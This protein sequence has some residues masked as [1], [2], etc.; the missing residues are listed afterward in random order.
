MSIL[1]KK[2]SGDLVKLM[3]FILVTSL[4]TG[5]LVVLIGNFTFESTRTYKAQ[6]SDATGVVKGDDIRIAGVKVGSVKDVRIV[7]RERAEVTFGVAR[8]SVVTKS[9]TATIRYRN[10]VGQRYIALT[11]GVGDLD[12][13][14][15]DATIPMDRTKPALDLTV[16]FNGFKPLFAALSP[17]DINKLSAEVISV[18]QGEGGTLTSLLQSTASLTNTL[19]DRDKVIGEVIDN[20]NAVLAT[21]AGRDKQLNELITDFQ[22]L[23]SGLVQDRGAILGSLDSV[24]ALADETSSLVIGIRPSL[25]RDVKGLRKVAANLNQGRGE[26]DRALQVLPIKLNKIGRTAIYGSFFNFYLCQFQGNVKVGNALT[27]P[28]KYDTSTFSKDARC[29]LG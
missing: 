20:L 9:S 18:F 3:I 23:M 27:V 2:T 22:R 25:V 6:F 4:A 28:I 12:R 11:Q 19:A 16:L 13:L 14:P 15:E 26:I 10:L 1:D 24:S 21:L 29:E 17:A 8:S 7:D 5:V